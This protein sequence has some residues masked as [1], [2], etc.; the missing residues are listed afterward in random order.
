MKKKLTSVI[1]NIIPWRKSYI[2]LFIL[3]FILLGSISAT[4]LMGWDQMQFHYTVLQIKKWGIYPYRDYC[5]IQFFG[6]Y[7]Y[8]FFIQTLFGK[9]HLG[10]RIFDIINHIFLCITVYITLPVISE[11]IKKY[12][13]IIIL[14]FVTAGYFSIGWW[15]NGQRESFLMPYIFWS[16]YCWKKSLDNQSSIFAF[17]SGLF[18]GIIL[19]IK[20]FYSIYLPLFLLINLIFNYPYASKFSQRFKYALISGTGFIFAILSFIIL[21]WRLDI[22]GEFIYNITNFAVEFKKT[23]SPFSWITYC[24]FF[25]FSP[26]ALNGKMNIYKIYYAMHLFSGII[27]IIFTVTKHR[28]R[29]I[30]SIVYI[31]A[32]SIFLVY[33]QGNGEVINHHIPMLYAKMIL[34]A[35][36][37]I[38]LSKIISSKILEKFKYLKTNLGLT[39]RSIIT[40]IAICAVTIPLMQGTGF[41]IELIKNCLQNRGIDYCRKIHY[42]QKIE[43]DKIISFINNIDGFDKNKDEILYFYYSPYIPYES[44]TKSYRYMMNIGPLI[45]FSKGSTMRNNF[46][47][48]LTSGIKKSRPKLIITQKDDAGWTNN[49]SFKGWTNSYDELMKIPGMETNIRQNY[50]KALELKSFIVYQRIK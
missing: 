27:F 35:L 37:F 6:I 15:W 21:L 5:D 42:P 2:I 8:H 49:T 45:F 25:Q 26:V 40:L 43:E 39:T 28:L 23:R 41:D 50:Q 47:K 18:C 10:F 9:S 4:M 38:E 13:L 22:L 20:P 19:N 11:R 48:T 14:I 46:I 33:Y 32:V 3:I 7:I 29:G 36:F 30:F 34:S 24:V 16:L 44:E 12:D 31:L 17:L 1:E